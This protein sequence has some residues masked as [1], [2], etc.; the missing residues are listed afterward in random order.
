MKSLESRF[1]AVAQTFHRIYK[2]SFT[3]IHIKIGSH[4]TLKYK[5]TGSVH[6]YVAN[7]GLDKNK[8][9]P[10]QLLYSDKNSEMSTQCFCDQLFQ[11]ARDVYYEARFHLSQVTSSLA[12]GFLDYEGS[13][14]LSG[15]YD[16]RNLCQTANLL[17]S[18]LCLRREISRYPM[19]NQFSQK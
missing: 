13:S 8:D 6:N 17:W 1:H 10:I 16:H 3:T 14:H 2:L 19:T 15:I 5:Q 11:C 7:R 12:L 9:A 4:L 18:R